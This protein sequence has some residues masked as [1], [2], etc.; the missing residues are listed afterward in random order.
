[1][2]LATNFDTLERRLFPD[3]FIKKDLPSDKKI[4]REVEKKLWNVIEPYTKSDFYYS[5]ITYSDW[6]QDL[7]KERNDFSYLPSVQKTHRMLKRMLKEAF[8]IE[9]IYMF[10]ERHSPEEEH[11]YEAFG[12]PHKGGNFL[13]KEHQVGD[14]KNKGR[15]HT[16][17]LMSS[18]KDERITNPNGKCRKLFDKCSN[19]FIPINQKHHTNIQDLKIDLITACCKQPD[20]VIEKQRDSVKT[21]VLHTPNDVKRV[22]H[23]CIKECYNNGTDF[24]EVVDFNNSDFSKIPK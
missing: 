5:V 6:L 7:D 23:Y 15:F 10:P 3:N 17:V 13:P 11:Y 22:L 16:N 4:T 20:W 9:H 19:S 8:K 12:I 18:I 24:T 2:K 1:M 14:V 21:Q